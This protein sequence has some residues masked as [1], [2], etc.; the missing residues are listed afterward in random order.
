MTE[1]MRRVIVQDV[2]TFVLTEA[3]VPQPGPGEVQVRT[4]VSGVCGSD[5]H[6]AHGRHP[7][8]PLPYAPGHE[9]VGVVSAVGEGVDGWAA[10]DRV[11]VEPTLPCGGCKMCTTGRS[12]LCENLRFF[13]CGYEQGGMADFFTIPATRLHRIPDDLDDLQ[14]ALI[15]PLSTPVHAVRLAGDVAGKAVVIIGAG[16]IGLLVLAAARHA[17]ARTIVM[18]D[19]LADKRERALRLGADAVV[20]A[21]SADA[22]AQIRDA[23]GE[24]ADVVFDCV[25]I[26]PTV[27][28]AIALADKAGTVVIVGVPARDVTVPLPIIQDHQIRIQGSATYLP[29]DYATAIEILRAGEVRAED[30]ITRR[31]PLEQVAEAFRLSASGAEVKVVVEV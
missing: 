8:V 3:P 27:D 20:D 22:V 11:T 21:A 19:M 25:A 26:Q 14:A 13:G 10:G 17:G 7:F 29:E 16:T 4:T 1:N 12:N 15:E 9:V 23:L 28:Q 24:S 18:T 31:L 5:T 2:D 30:M 6:A